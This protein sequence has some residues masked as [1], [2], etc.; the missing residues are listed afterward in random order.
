Q[1]LVNSGTYVFSI[2]RDAGHVERI[3]IRQSIQPAFFKRGE[4]ERH[5]RSLVPEVCLRATGI[6]AGKEKVGI[7]GVEIGELGDL[8]AGEIKAKQVRPVAAIRTEN[9]FA[10]I[11]PRIGEVEMM[12][13]RFVI[14]KLPN[15]HAGLGI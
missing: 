15:L 1:I 2:R 13:V 3:T 9:Q 6:E 4:V 12:A 11:P 8:P 7:G 14:R 10:I 5:Q